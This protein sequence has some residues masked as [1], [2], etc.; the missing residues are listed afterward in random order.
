MKQKHVVI[1]EVADLL[2]IVRQ[3]TGQEDCTVI[4]AIGSVNS[5]MKPTVEITF[6]VN[7]TSPAKQA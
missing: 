1:L 5:D 7:A 3:V 4:G 6:T 2:N